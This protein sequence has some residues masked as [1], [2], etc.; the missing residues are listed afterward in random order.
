M[1]NFKKIFLTTLVFILLY[2]QTRGFIFDYKL[3]CFENEKHQTRVSPLLEEEEKKKF[4]LFSQIKYR[5][6]NIITSIFN[7][8]I[9]FKQNYIAD[10]I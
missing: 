10:R 7:Y 4:I 1:F 6:N 3:S 9:T 5:E 8:N 2:S